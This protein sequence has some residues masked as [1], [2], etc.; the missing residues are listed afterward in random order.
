MMRSPVQSDFV[1]TRPSHRRAGPTRQHHVPGTREPPAPPGFAVHDDLP[2]AAQLITLPAA[3]APLPEARL[4]STEASA[5]ATRWV[6][7]AAVV[8]LLA[9]LALTTVG[10]HI[11]SGG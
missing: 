6:L 8:L 11:P 1:V 3:R 4:R 9:L 7:R 5:F 2:L 10:A